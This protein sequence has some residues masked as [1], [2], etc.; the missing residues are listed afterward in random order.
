MIPIRGF[1]PD[2]SPDTPGVLTACENVIP[3]EAGFKGAPVAVSVG[4]AAL[5]AAC[6]G[7]ALV[8]DLSGTRKIYAGSASKLYQLAGSSW[9]DRTRAVGGDYTLGAD[10][11]WSIAQFGDATLAASP[12]EA[13]QR[14]T[15]G[16][17]ADVSGA[18]QAKII[19]TAAGF[20]V[21]FNTS[22]SADT[23][24]CSAYLDDTDWSL[25]V[26][27]QCVTGRL[28]GGA[29]PITAAK[30]FG[31]DIVAYKDASVFVGRYVGAPA[32]WQ[33]TQVANDVGALGQDAVC[34]TAIG[35][36]FAAS[37]GLYVFDGTAPRPLGVGVIRRWLAQEFAGSYAFRT[38]LLWDRAR[39]LVWCY[40][41]S[42]G[43]DGT[44]DR[45]AVYNVV[46]QQWGRANA[47]IE[48]A[49]THQT[50][51]LTYGASSGDGGITT[52]DASPAIPFDSAFW[53]SGAQ[54]AAVFNSSHVLCTLSGGCTS[55]SFTTGDLGD[56]GGYSFCRALR[57]RYQ[58]APTT[59]TATGYTKDTSG[60][61]VAS[62]ASASVS[63]G[64][65]DMRQ[66]ARWH[67]F[68]VE[69]TGDWSANAYRAELEQAGR[70]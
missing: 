55:S 41:P 14:A 67:R 19:E 5:A 15:T 62:V 16:A 20:A 63:D 28:V 33:W 3:Y 58:Q 51:A 24:Y 4:A 11:R 57:V 49:L 61:A 31:D 43:G 38:T 30:R 29:G 8:S 45:C 47:T 10:E 60:V 42:P 59:S 44:R 26:S 9:T 17:F 46:T 18:P 65:H 1:A 21:A 13:L 7:A 70:R 36:V 12:G 32:V 37:D 69:Q 53:Q 48:A 22:V 68:H 25:D 23:W 2:Q 40:Y 66:R 27:T 39:S 64:R 50:P 56:D 6:R 54:T 52:Y 34:D 35:H